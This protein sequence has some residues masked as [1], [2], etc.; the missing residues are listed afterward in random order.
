MRIPHRPRGEQGDRP[1]S[2]AAFF[3]REMLIRMVLAVAVFI[4]AFAAAWLGSLL[5]WAWAPFAFAVLTVV[6]GGAAVAALA[7]RVG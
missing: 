1:G 7:R 4:L 5:P 6:L 2:F 3:F